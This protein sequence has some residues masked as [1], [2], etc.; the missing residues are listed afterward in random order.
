MLGARLYAV[1]RTVAVRGRVT[2]CHES[3]A[4]ER[5]AWLSAADRRAGIGIP[6]LGLLRRRTARGGRARCLLDLDL[7]RAM[8]SRDLPKQIAMQ[9]QLLA[10]RLPKRV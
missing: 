10:I 6:E 8:L 7:A 2:T 9:H 1:V 4:A 3:G 5:Q